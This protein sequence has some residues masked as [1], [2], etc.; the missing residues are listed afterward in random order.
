MNKIFKIA[1]VAREAIE[2]Y[3]IFSGDENSILVSISK[4]N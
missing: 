1:D 4:K 2:E 3:Q